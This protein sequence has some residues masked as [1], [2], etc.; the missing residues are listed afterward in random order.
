[1]TRS[2]FFKTALA[3]VAAPIIAKLEPLALP[4]CPP[5]WAKQ[6]SQVTTSGWYEHYAIF[7]PLGDGN[8]EVH[9]P[10]GT[11]ERGEIRWDRKSKL[12]I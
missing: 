2:D 5:E 6:F 9:Y 7:V 1:M 10:D 3:F 11:V 12:K 4:S 8:M